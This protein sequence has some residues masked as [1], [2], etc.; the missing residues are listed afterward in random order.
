MDEAPIDDALIGRTI[1]D[2]F[3]IEALVG[4]GAMGAVYK[5]RQVTLQRKIALK[6]MKVHGKADA[7][8]AA[9]F[10]REAKTASLLDHPNLVRVLD[11]GQ[12]PDGVLY[13]AME[14]LE[15]RNLLAALR[16]W[17]FET[18]RIV[19]ILTQTLSALAV[20]HDTGIVH[21]DLKPE[22][23]MLVH[24]KDE[25]GIETETVKVCDFGVAKFDEDAAVEPPHPSMAVRTSSSNTTTLTAHGMT[26]GTPSYMAP[27]QA[28]GE[29]TDARSDIYAVGVILFQLLTRRLPFEAATALKVMIEHI[30][31]PV[32][33]PSSFVPEVDPRLERVCLKALRKR[34]EKRYQSAREM[35]ADLRA[36]LES[37][38]G[39]AKTVEK[40]PSNRPGKPP[41]G[42]ND[43]PTIPPSSA[44]IPRVVRGR[45]ERARG[46]VRSA[47]ILAIVLV[48]IGAVLAV[49]GLARS[50]G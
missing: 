3:E 28:L 47:W 15:G 17:P 10:A 48:L 27:E 11:F 34:P 37:P 32:P 39:S 38:S 19:T 25:D 22:N 31:K 14:Y 43:V 49:L 23:I 12:E 9:R 40:S 20:A 41:K 44:D 26:V 18:D 24:T 13:I 6:V 35:R 21:R 30:E 42:T 45:D 1:A 4:R 2:K 8:Y 5:A 50:R 33:A 7:K 46:S 36:A 16:D 29:P